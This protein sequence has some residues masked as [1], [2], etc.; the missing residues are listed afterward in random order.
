SQAWDHKHGAEIF[1]ETKSDRICFY[2]LVL[3]VTQHIRSLHDRLQGYQT[4]ILSVFIIDSINREVISDLDADG[5]VDKFLQ[6]SL[7]KR[8]CFQNPY[9]FQCVQRKKLVC[10]Q[11]R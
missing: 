6:K 7:P 2:D 9:D 8:C 1:R 10:K 4:N 3:C 11:Q 5:W